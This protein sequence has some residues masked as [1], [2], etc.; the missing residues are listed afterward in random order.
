[1][2]FKSAEL[3][4]LYEQMRALGVLID[5]SDAARLFRRGELEDLVDLIQTR[6][7]RYNWLVAEVSRI[8][9]LLLLGAL[10]VDEE[11]LLRLTLND[12]YLELEELAPY[13]DER[14]R[15]SSRPSLQQS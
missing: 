14:E 7:E 9:A 1:M 15:W 4:S 13:F 12:Y 6:T 10:D 8:E 3:K 2:P 11:A 5:A